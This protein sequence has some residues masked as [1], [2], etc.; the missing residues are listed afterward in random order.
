MI[1]QVEDLNDDVLW[2]WLCK[3]L[4]TVIKDIIHFLS[5]R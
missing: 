5:L 4:A 1:K 3:G 2:I